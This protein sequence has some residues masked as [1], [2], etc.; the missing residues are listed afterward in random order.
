[1]AEYM[2]NEREMLIYLSNKKGLEEIAKEEHKATKY[3]YFFGGFML[4]FGLIFMA[5]SVW[6]C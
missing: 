5:Y 3:A 1:M 2:L 4:G 6:G